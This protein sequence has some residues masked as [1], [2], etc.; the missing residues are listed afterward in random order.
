MD[1]INEMIKDVNEEF[2]KDSQQTTEKFNNNE[3][4][5][6]QTNEH[7]FTRRRKNRSRRVKLTLT[8]YIS[9]ILFGPFG[10]LYVRATKAGGS[11]DKVWLFLPLFWL[12]PFSLVPAYYLGRGKVRAGNDKNPVTGISGIMLASIALAAPYMV[13]ALNLGELGEAFIPLIVYLASII[14]FFI[15]NRKRCSSHT[16]ARSS[17]SSSILLIITTFFTMSFKYIFANIAMFEGL[18]G[19]IYESPM[20]ENILYAVL[21]YTSYAS[22]NMYNNTPS[23]MKFCKRVKS[24]HLMY[25]LLSTI[26][27]AMINPII[28]KQDIDDDY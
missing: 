23:L 9:I 8:N 13:K 26:F 7:L 11:L 28:L 18:F 19:T 16:F 20:L 14:T 6:V 27:I 3:L 15:R 22:V 4:H 25:S 21:V 10:Q 1:F 24:H 5:T 2:N 12:P 17:F